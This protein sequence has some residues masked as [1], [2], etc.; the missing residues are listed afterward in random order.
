MRLFLALLLIALYSLTPTGSAVAQAL[1]GESS[2]KALAVNSAENL[3]VNEDETLDRPTLEPKDPIGSANLDITARIIGGATAE[4]NAYPSLVALVRPG[5]GNFNA[6]LFCGGTVVATRWVMTAAHCLFDSFDQP[7]EP[8]RVRVVEGTN[9]LAQNATQLVRDVA[10]IIVHPD[11]DITLDLQPFDLAL[12]ELVQDSEQPTATLFAGDT[13]DL[14]DRFAS[15]AGWGATNF[16]NP[17]NP[18]FP[19]VLQDAA[20]PIIQN[21]VCNAP[22]SYDGAI[23]PSQVCAGFREGGVDAC[24]GD[25]GGPLYI[26]ENNQLV[27]VGITSFGIGCAEPLFYGIYTDISHF[28]PWLSQFF[29]VPQQSP[30]LIEQLANPEPLATPIRNDPDDNFLERLF[31]G[32]IGTGTHV[33]L[34]LSL[35]ARLVFPRQTKTRVTTKIRT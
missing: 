6:R 18:Q 11:F 27:Q 1:L 33:L 8:Q 32:A 22:D 21:D 25:S 2:G 13:T 20:V 3:P 24:V 28:L 17:S 14:V 5:L 16:D 35:L 7:L 15:I 4:A 29:V 23:V 31:G 30:E 34:A 9:D 10:Q 12:L 19:S 26:E